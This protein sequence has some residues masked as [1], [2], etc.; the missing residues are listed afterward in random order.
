M[1]LMVFGIRKCK[2]LQLLRFQDSSVDQARLD[3]AADGPGS[4]SRLFDELETPSV[5][6]R[7]KRHH[8]EQIIH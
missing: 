8:A 3:Q 1:Y 5:S 2:G 4:S 6:D 7:D